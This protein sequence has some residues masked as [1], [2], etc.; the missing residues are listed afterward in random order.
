MSK[1]IMTLIQKLE[2]FLQGHVKV[3][4]DTDRIHG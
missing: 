2:I 4:K 3:H 1:K